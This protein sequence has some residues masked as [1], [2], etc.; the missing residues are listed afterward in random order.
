MSEVQ[1][2]NEALSLVGTRS[3]ITSLSES[4]A[5]AQQCNLRYATVRDRI[6]RLAPWN[7]AKKVDTA[8]MLKA[9][10][11]TP[12][13]TEA[14]GVWSNSWPPPPW[15][16]SYTYP[17]DCLL[18]RAVL[19]QPYVLESAT[20]PIYP[21]TQVNVAPQFN[22][23]ARFSRGQD[24]DVNGNIVQGIF[25]NQNQAILCYTRRVTETGLFDTMFYSA[26]VNALAGELSFPLTGETRQSQALY[27]QANSLIISARVSD[28]NESMDVLDHTPDWLRVRG[29]GTQEIAGIYTEPYGPLFGGI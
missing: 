24:T 7:F 28:A 19:P 3:T 8:A 15:C 16:Y 2:C 13:N 18:L 12:E 11:G 1:I 20:T 26:L 5:E 6:L 17:A 14:S 23:A 21:Y 27:A 4:S 22:R 10:P 25:T 29:I 9:A